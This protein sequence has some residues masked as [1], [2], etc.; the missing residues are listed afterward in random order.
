MECLKAPHFK[1]SFFNFD[2]SLNQSDLEI[3]L[4]MLIF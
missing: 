2:L 4:H 3:K 1:L